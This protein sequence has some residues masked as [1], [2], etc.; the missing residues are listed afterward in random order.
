[1][2]GVRRGRTVIGWF[3]MAKGVAN[4]PRYAEV[5]LSA[6]RRY[7]QARA[8]VDDPGEAFAAASCLAGRARAVA[9]RGQG[10]YNSS[11]T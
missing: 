4:L 1:M 7:I 3:P 8:V 5:C 11:V 2:R 10:M 6:N 9:F